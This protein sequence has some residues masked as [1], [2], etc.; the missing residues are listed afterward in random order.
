MITNQDL[1]ELYGPENVVTV[2]AD[3][4][5]R[6]RVRDADAEVLARVGI[7][8]FSPVIF[9]NHVEGEPPFLEVFD[10]ETKDGSVH[11]EVLLGWVPD[12]PVINFS[13][14]AQQG[15]V[16][17]VQ[18]T[19][20]PQFDVVNNNLAEFVEFLYLI[21]RFRMQPVDDPEVHEKSRHEL[22]D[23]LRAMDPFSFE[24]PDLWWPKVLARV[25]APGPGIDAFA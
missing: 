10:V 14:D 18:R 4:V 7:P 13:L 24:A 17:F 23:R 16:T 19:D 3:E 21:D 1:V 9:T 11:R 22:R 12:D 20:P 2:P 5:E 6:L 15:F 25:A 8:A